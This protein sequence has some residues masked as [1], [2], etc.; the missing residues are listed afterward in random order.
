VINHFVEVFDAKK[1]RVEQ[2]MECIDSNSFQMVA[3]GGAGGDGDDGGGTVL[4]PDATALQRGFESQTQQWKAEAA[5]RVFLE[6]PD[7]KAPT[8][9]IDFYKR[10]KSP[11]F[12][13]AGMSARP[14]AQPVVAL[15]R[16][17]RSK[18]TN[19]W[20]AEDAEGIAEM[21][22][23]TEEDVCASDAY[24]QA[25]EVMVRPGGFKSMPKRYYNDYSKMEVWM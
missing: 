7:S 15:Y 17:Q 10:G 2:L 11:A 21:Q 9:A 25:L 16:V 20:V 19:V 6:I 24:M 1:R 4:V 23:A 13:V 14:A 18:I 12:G 22:G 5:K 3:L 8:F